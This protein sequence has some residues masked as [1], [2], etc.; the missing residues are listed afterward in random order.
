MHDH[1]IR[2]GGSDPELHIFLLVFV[3]RLD[4]NSIDPIREIGGKY[5]LDSDSYY[6]DFKYMCNIDRH[7]SALEI[8]KTVDI[9]ELFEKF[10]HNVDC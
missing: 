9:L 8:K 4:F 6:N 7:L 1:Y 2:D 5:Y 3:M 10:Y